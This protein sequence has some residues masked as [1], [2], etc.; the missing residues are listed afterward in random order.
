MTST[1]DTAGLLAFRWRASGPEVLLVH[2][3]G[4]FWRGRDA[5]SWSFPKGQI[6]PGETPLCAAKREFQEETGLTI[7]APTVALT[8]I[9]RTG[10]GL[11]YCWL[12]EADLDLRSA[13]SNR[14]DITRLGRGQESYPEVDAYAYCD[15]P[16]C[17]RR[18]HRSI[19]PL[20]VEA[21]DQLEARRIGCAAPPD[22][23]HRTCPSQPGR[24]QLHLAKEMLAHTPRAQVDGP[25]SHL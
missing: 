8:P 5:E 22:G 2:P 20:L 19:R 3:G 13:H 21:F 14:F 24:A 11:A 4:P 10:K 17:L 9:R 23:R 7:V 1:S 16:T 25:G 12:V 15:R 18:I 6:E